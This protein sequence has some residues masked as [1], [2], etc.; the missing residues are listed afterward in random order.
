MH[1]KSI[2]CLEF[3]LKYGWDNCKVDNQRFS[4]KFV[5]SGLLE[6]YGFSELE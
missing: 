2:S 3:F 4:Q 1:A 5:T 6:I